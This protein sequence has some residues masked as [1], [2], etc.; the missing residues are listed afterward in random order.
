[1]LKP[2]SEKT[3]ERLMIK[4]DSLKTILLK[5]SLLSTLKNFLSLKKEDEN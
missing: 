2:P 4:N 1:M 5:I 3:I